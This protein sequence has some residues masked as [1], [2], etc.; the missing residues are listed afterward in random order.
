MRK[1]ISCCGLLC[2]ECPAYIATMEDDDEKR[3]ETAELWSQIYNS[4]I[5]V[6]DINCLGCLQTEG[7]IF[8][9][10]NICKIRSCCFENGTENCAHCFNYP[11]E[12]IEEFFK[13]APEAKK[14]LDGIKEGIK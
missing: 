11:C 2:S 1:K 5:K 13:I 14:I 4:D 7:T 10:C 6:S 9:Y 3:R 8:S 12:K